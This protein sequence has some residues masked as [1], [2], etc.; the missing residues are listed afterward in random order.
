MLLTITVSTSRCQQKCSVVELQ[1]Q[2]WSH[3]QNI[4]LWV[5]PMLYMNLL[6]IRVVTVKK[7]SNKTYEFTL[8]VKLMLL[9]S[10]YILGAKYNY[11][12]L[13]D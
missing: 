13:T 3:S 12:T 6:F 10:F 5:L 11:R 4:N 8:T 2:T 9:G 1:S 7:A